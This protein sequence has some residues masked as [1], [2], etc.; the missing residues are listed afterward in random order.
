MGPCTVRATVNGT[1]TNRAVSCTLSQPAG[2]LAILMAQP[3]PDAVFKNWTG[4]YTGTAPTCTVMMRSDG[5]A[6]ALYPTKP[7][8]LASMK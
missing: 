7:K 6:L 5:L 8:G 2:T 1:T 3:S 4:S